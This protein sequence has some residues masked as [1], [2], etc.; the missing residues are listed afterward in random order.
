VRFDSLPPPA[1]GRF[2]A[3][4]AA[5]ARAALRPHSWSPLRNAY[6]IFGLAWG[7]PVP[8]ATLSV[9]CL[10][11]GLSWSP[12]TLV[13]V[14]A[15]SPV[16]W[17]FMLHPLVFAGIFGSI[18]TVANDHALT[19]NRM[20]DKL[21]GLAD[22]D[23]LTGLLN[24]RAFQLRVR[25]EAAR[26]ER[27]ETPIALLMIDIDHFKRLNDRYGHQGGDRV[28]VELARRMLGVVRPYDVVTRYGGEEFAVLLPGLDGPEAARAA[29]RIRLAVAS[30]P[31]AVD[32]V[33]TPVTVSIGVATHG[34][35][36]SIEAWI[37]H[38]D[39]RLYQ[40]K[41]TGRNRTTAPPGSLPPMRSA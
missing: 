14:L 17:L 22:T 41:S 2:G 1:D 19:V 24:H 36:E 25:E 8:L 28:L 21:K 29:E 33:T 39:Q 3:Q 11:R 37:D 32:G 15:D 27:E 38:A 31:F 10:A 34:T 16:Q 30:T 7:L 20:V 40:S 12:A 35:S 23:G 4:L 26:A 5:V 18:G 9:E 6:V 13:A